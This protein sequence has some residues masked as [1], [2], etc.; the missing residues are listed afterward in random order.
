MRG[1]HLV[2]P[3]GEARLAEDLPPRTSSSWTVFRR[4]ATWNWGSIFVAMQW[5]CTP[6]VWTEMGSKRGRFWG[7]SEEN[8]KKSLTESA[9][10]PLLAVLTKTLDWVG[11]WMTSYSKGSFHFGSYKWGLF[12][13]STPQ[14]NGHLGFALLWRH[15]WRCLYLP[16]NFVCISDHM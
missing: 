15:V 10:K 9:W 3:K 5:E 4:L 1:G 8:W 16:L 2:W 7:N 14:H 11:T 12:L 13:N 6:T